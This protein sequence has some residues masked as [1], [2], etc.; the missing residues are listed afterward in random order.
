M[1]S[2]SARKKYIRRVP[3][4]DGLFLR[5]LLTADL[6]SATHTGV[7]KDSSC[8][9]F[10]ANNFKVEE[11]PHRTVEVEAEN[12]EDEEEDGVERSENLTRRRRRRRIAGSLLAV[13]LPPPLAP[14]RR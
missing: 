5:A 13:N 9:T 4:A 10:P 12:D 1:K 3:F 2:K 14:R 6:T 11:P 7:R 8:G